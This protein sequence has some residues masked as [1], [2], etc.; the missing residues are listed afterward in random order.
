MK[1]QI[2]K[3]LLTGLVLFC[4]A[5]PLLAQSEQGTDMKHRGQSTM[6]FLQVAVVPRAVALGDAYTALGTGVEAMFYNPAGLGE[7]DEKTQFFV[8]QMQWIAD[9]NYFAGAAAY[10][11]DMYGTVGVSFVYV[12]YGDIHGT[13]LFLDSDV[14]AADPQGYIDNGL[15][16]NVGS[17]VLGLGYAY[18]VTDVFKVG[19]SLKFAT[20]KLGTSVTDEGEVKNDQSKLAFDLGVKYYTPLKSFRFGMSIRNFTSDVKYENYPASLPVCFAVGGAVD[21]M[22]FIQPEMTSNDNEMLAT[23]EFTHP[24]NYTERLH[25][26]VD[27][28]WKQLLSLR[29]GYMTNHD[30]NGFSMGFGLF[31]KIGDTTTELSYT[32]SKMDV[33]DD[34]NRFSLKFA[35]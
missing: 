20:Q 26:G 13:S 34:V 9:I 24:N 12:D 8:S 21:L 32:Y 15:V 19:G 17:Y 1:K 23:V 14:A 33:F 22:D 10:D 5:M 28:A 27:Y 6:D 11:L 2:N 31:P 3:I 4:A 35:F 18:D 30:V 7:M 29:M 16:D 25:M